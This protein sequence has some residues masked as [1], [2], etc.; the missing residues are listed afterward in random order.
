M[1][2]AKYTKEQFVEAVARN[3]SIRQVL[4]ELGLRPTGGNYKMVHYK[5][6]ILNLETSHW[7]GQGHL[8]G[9]VN[10]WHPKQKLED[11]LVKNSTYRGG[12]YK[13]KKRLIKEGYFEKKCYS[14]L[15]TE[16]L[17]KSIPLELEHKNGNRFDNRIRNLTLLCPNCH[18]LTPT[19]RGKN[20]SRS[21]GMADAKSDWRR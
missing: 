8:K 15:L 16:W 19:Y 12:T 1:K 4:I 13:L 3:F 21:G 5:V 11:I 6:G 14:C 17:G 18:A 10:Y 20:K 2:H 7:T 9:K